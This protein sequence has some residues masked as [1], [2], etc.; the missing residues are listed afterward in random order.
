[1]EHGSYSVSGRSGHSEL[2]VSNRDGSRVTQLT[3]FDG[4]RVGSPSWSADGKRI[5]FD[6]TL[7]GTG[8]WNLYIVAADG[9]PVEPLTSDALQQH[10]AELVSR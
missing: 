5:A 4:W 8:S 1:M 10:S 6:A 7:T 2:W 3:H 9:G